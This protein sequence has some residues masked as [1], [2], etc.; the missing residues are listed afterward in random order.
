MPYVGIM[1]ASLISI[2]KGTEA[3]FDYFFKPKQNYHYFQHRY[4]AIPESSCGTLVHISGVLAFREDPSAV[5]LANSTFFFI[6]L[7][8]ASVLQ[9]ATLI[10]LQCPLYSWSNNASRD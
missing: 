8:C 6:L 9:V 1:L 3:S 2:I 7:V 4:K 10:P 5:L